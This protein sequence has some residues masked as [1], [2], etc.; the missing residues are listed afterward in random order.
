MTVFL[1][2][3]LTFFT[4]EAWFHLRQHISARNSRYW[5]SANTRQTFEVL[6]CDPKIGVLCAITAA[7][8]VR[9]IFNI[10]NSERF[11]FCNTLKA[12]RIPI[13]WLLAKRMVVQW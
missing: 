9:P 8:I 10:I 1:I 6:L 3:N 7:W 11:P 4:D 13:G 12:I 2:Q 5:S